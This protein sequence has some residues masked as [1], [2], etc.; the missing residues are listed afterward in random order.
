MG[1]S[2]QPSFLKVGVTIPHFQKGW[3]IH[4]VCCGTCLCSSLKK[5][6]H[7]RSKTRSGKQIIE[8]E[9]WRGK[10]R[11]VLLVSSNFRS[12]ACANQMSAVDHI[13]NT[14]VKQDYEVF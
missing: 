13:V 12:P 5:M 14:F 8:K 7:C 11:K 1:D 9:T 3:L 10:A 4:L 6:D 2:S